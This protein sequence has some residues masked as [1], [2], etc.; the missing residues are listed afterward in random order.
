MN[1]KQAT[2]SDLPSLEVKEEDLVMKAE[3]KESSRVKPFKRQKPASEV[4]KTKIIILLL[5][6]VIQSEFIKAHVRRIHIQ[7][8][9]DR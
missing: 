6:S 8:D 9:I 3:R 4:K 1:I 2:Y 7:V 5:Y